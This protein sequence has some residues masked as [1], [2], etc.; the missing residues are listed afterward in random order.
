MGEVKVRKPKELVI[1]YNNETDLN[2]LYTS[3]VFSNFILGETLE[4]IEEAIETNKTE[5]HIINISNH[6]FKI[7]INR[8]QFEPAIN[9]VL[10]KFKH[11]DV[12]KMDIEGS[13]YDVIEDILN[14]NISITQ[15]L[16]EFHDRLFENGYQK[17]IKVIN[18]L[19]LK[20]YEIFA[21]SESFEEVSFINKNIL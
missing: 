13:E 10:K 15:I 20:G 16:V 21:V 19:K 12:L 7:T 3:D 11:I 2:E 9:N 5:A 1:N 8:D 17:S 4:A 6:K 18:A 14:S